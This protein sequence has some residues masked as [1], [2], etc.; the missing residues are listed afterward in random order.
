MK[1]AFLYTDRYGDYDYGPTHPLKLIRQGLTQDLI[2]AYGLLGLPSVQ[3]VAMEEATEE[4]IRT[5]HT[6][7]YLDALRKANEGRPF[8]N[9]GKYGFGFGDNPIF[10]GVYDLARTASGGSIQAAEL[11]GSGEVAVAFN[12]AGGLHHALPDRA[13]GFC[14]IND[15][16]LA[17]HYL[18]AQGK[19]VA[20][21]DIDAHHGDGVQYAFYDTDRVLTISLHESGRFLFPGT[22]FETEAGEGAGEGYAVNVPLSPHAGDAAFVWA[23]EEV[24]PPLI[25]AYRPDV[26]VTQLGVDTF[27]SD[28]ITHLGVTTEGFCRMVER[29]RTFELPWV[30]LGGGGYDVANVARGW[31]LAWALMND[32]EVPNDLP[33][34]YVEEAERLGVHGRTLRDAPG[35]EETG[36]MEEARRSVEILKNSVFPIVGA[37]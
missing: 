28:P 32:A 12:I 3:V 24:V 30:A 17:I 19:R 15:P 11:V 36:G 31:T 20:Y 8:P 35:A 23:F 13:S 27:R 14:Y 29:F 26:L 10:S 25:N 37:G 9:A 16:A 2:R 18:V 5:F 21:V 4:E 1:T 7:D 34:E 33:T 22:G 6:R